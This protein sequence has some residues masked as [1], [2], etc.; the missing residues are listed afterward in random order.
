MGPLR[1]GSS[2]WN[3]VLSYLVRSLSLGYILDVS[4][5][6]RDVCFT[7]PCNVCTTKPNFVYCILSLLANFVYLYITVDLDTQLIRFWSLLFFCF[8]GAN[9]LPVAEAARLPGSALRCAIPSLRCLYP[10]RG[11]ARRISGV[12]ENRKTY[13]SMAISMEYL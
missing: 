3:E 4:I 6:P 1:N 8:F 9:K 2:N 5:Y 13:K 10:H 7:Y 11:A 12:A